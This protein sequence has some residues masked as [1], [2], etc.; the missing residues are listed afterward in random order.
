VR[1]IGPLSPDRAAR[2]GDRGGEVQALLLIRASTV[3][4]DKKESDA[5]SEGTDQSETLLMMINR[6]FTLSASKNVLQVGLVHI[7]P[8]LDYFSTLCSNYMAVLLGQPDK[9]R[10]R[11]FAENP[12]QVPQR[13]AYVMG[14]SSRLYV[15]T[16]INVSADI[17]GRMRARPWPSLAIAKGLSQHIDAMG[18]VNLETVHAELL[19]YCIADDPN[20]SW[21]KSGTEEKWVDIYKE[22]KTLLI[23]ALV[24]AE[25]HSLASEILERF[26]LSASIGDKC[27][28]GSAETMLKA[29]GH[30]Y[31]SLDR[32]KVEESDLIS[33][34]EKLRDVEAP[35]MQQWLR[36]VIEDFK[37]AKPSDYARSK[38]GSLF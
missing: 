8:L 32:A 38:L 4:L 16:P 37:T 19:K 11:L 17:H 3:R 22:V 2:A 5:E 36:Q 33:F 1:L 14:T 15:E 27:L 35:W 29:L 23:L 12:A 26:W 31:G 20:F 10:A 25:L 6:I 9:M 18:L 28:N 24:D 21:P 7:A 30:L 13:L 34:F